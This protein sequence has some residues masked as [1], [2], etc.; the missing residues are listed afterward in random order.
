MIGF[1]VRAGG[2]VAHIAGV[3]NEMDRFTGPVTVLTTDD[4]PTLKPAV[5]VVHVAPQLAAVH[6]QHARAHS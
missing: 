3:V 5:R 1:G 6:L 4:V 2:S